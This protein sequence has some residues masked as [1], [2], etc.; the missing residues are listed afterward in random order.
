MDKRRQVT[1]VNKRIRK[2][3]LYIFQEAGM[4]GWD[5]ILCIDSEEVGDLART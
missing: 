1:S 2:E 5:K 4:Y 3:S